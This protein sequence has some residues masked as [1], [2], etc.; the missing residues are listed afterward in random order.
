MSIHVTSLCDVCL[1]ITISHMYHY[2]CLCVSVSILIPRHQ[3]PWCLPLHYYLTHVSSLQSLRLSLYSFHV[4]SLCDVCLY[5][6]IL[7]IHHYLSGHIIWIYTH[8]HVPVYILKLCHQ[9]LQCRSKHDHL[10]YIMVCLYV[11]VYMYLSIYI[12]LHTQMTSPVS[13]EYPSTYSLNIDRTYSV[14][15]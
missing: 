8:I 2:F 1:Y 4:T 9:S 3:S 5:I 13:I 12:C 15:K 6:M 14:Y 11:S 10:V 7:Y